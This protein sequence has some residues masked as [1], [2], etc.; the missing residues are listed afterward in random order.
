MNE[1]HSPP[2]QLILN[3]QPEVMV[4]CHQQLFKK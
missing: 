1:L 4:A 3:K 2:E